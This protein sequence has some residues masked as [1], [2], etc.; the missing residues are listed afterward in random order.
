MAWIGKLTDVDSG[1]NLELVKM[2]NRNRI[3]K[4][5]VFARRDMEKFT[6]EWLSMQM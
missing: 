1:T 5:I 6:A 2:K 4:C 3:V